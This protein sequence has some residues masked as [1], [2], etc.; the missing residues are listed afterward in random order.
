MSLLIAKLIGAFAQPLGIALALQV[1][2]LL[3]W[4][5]KP[6]LAAGCLAVAIAWLWAISTPIV[7]DALAGFLEAR[8]PAVPIAGLPQADAIVVLGGGVEPAVPPRTE[9]ELSAAADR[10][11]LAAKL[12][13][14][15]KAP[16]VLATG[17]ALPWSDKGSEAPAMKELLQ[18]WGVPESAIVLESDSRT[19]RENAELVAPLLRER[20]IRRVLL[21]TSAM[22]MPRALA[23]F[24]AV[25]INAVPASADIHATAVKHRHVFDFLPAVDAVSLAGAALREYEGLIYYRAQGWLKAVGDASINSTVP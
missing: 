21:V 20:G 13:K 5:W 25:G 18:D 17:G 12:F 11:W 22:H 3:L 8:Y 4:K 7:A 10:V 19:T 6:K 14:A 2:A 1:L 24:A 15:A 16:F 23:C 9:I